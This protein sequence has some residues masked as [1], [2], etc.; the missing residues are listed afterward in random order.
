MARRSDE[1]GRKVVVDPLR[2]L[3]ERAAIAGLRRGGQVSCGGGTR[4]LR[5]ADGWLALSLTRP[6]DVDLLPAW[7][8]IGPI[9]IEDAWEVVTG[10]VRS[11]DVS[12]LVQQ[13]VLL[14]LPVG[15]L[16]ADGSRGREPTPA[17]PCRSTR[18]GDAPPVA[19]MV[20]DVVVADLGS[21]WAGP[22]CGSLLA[23]AG[24]QV[25]KVESTKRPDGARRGAE[26][27]FDLLNAGKRSVALD[28]TAPSGRRMLT[29]LLGRA[30]VVI[31]A[32][33]PRALEQLGIDAAAA[34]CGREPAR[35]GCRSPATAAPATTAT[36]SASVTTPP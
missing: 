15:A 35:S 26:A 23:E 1:V 4:L 34:R 7:L 2:L 29:S 31:E 16:P 18:I 11:R 10:A 24:A 28:F 8:G 21:L 9:A 14:G 30:D 33:R 6:N 17:L 22:L 3:G 13:A 25:I 36:G 20:R 5:A 27:F 12:T 32:S 19:G